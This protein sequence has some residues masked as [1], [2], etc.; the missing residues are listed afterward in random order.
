MENKGRGK[1][2]RKRRRRKRNERR[3]TERGGRRR[4]RGRR[5]RKGREEKMG[6]GLTSE[7]FGSYIHVWLLHQKVKV[8]SRILSS[9]RM[10]EE[11]I[12]TQFW[13]KPMKASHKE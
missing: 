10:E 9:F 5:G 1:R 7:G 4:R 3:R 2:S 8:G 12:F 13:A 6:P 11:A